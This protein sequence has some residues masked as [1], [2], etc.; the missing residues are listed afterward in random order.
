LQALARPFTPAQRLHNKSDFDR[1]YRDAKRSA[2]ALFAVFARPKPGSPPRLG[3]SIAAR[4]VGNAVRR[5]RIKRL[6]RESFRL[7]QHDLPAA[8]IVV[9]ARNGARNADNA[10]IVQSLERHWRNLS[11]QCASS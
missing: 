11:K 10:S 4:T 8:D 7:H 3:L 5:N 9:N 6:I 2:D 1:V